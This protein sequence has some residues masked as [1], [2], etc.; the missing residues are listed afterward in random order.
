MAREFWI[1]QGGLGDL[2]RV[3]FKR[4][5]ETDIHVRE[6]LP[7]E[8]DYK[9]LA[10]ELAEALEKIQEKNHT[11]PGIEAPREELNVR[12]ARTYEIARA[13]LSSAREK[14]K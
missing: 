11:D 14:M 10:E 2:H 9:K 8:P 4:R 6:V 7:D 3:F 13:A 5:L 1:E 12:A